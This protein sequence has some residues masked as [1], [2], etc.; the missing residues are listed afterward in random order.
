[1]DL[2]QK[3]KV[4]VQWKQTQDIWEEYRDTACHCREK[5]AAAEAQLEL[6]TAAYR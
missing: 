4:Y 2:R 1:M 3:R 6:N 5:S